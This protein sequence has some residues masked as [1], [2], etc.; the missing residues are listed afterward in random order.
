MINSQGNAYT[1]GNL[2]TSMSDHLPQVTIIE[3][4]LSDT[5]VKKDVR[6]LK[7]D[8][9]KFHSDNSIRDLKSVHWSVAT[10]NNPNI[11]FLKLHAYH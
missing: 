3:N 6:T 7:R 10:Q 4:L 9:P 1:S 5:R 8:F 2:T 11:G